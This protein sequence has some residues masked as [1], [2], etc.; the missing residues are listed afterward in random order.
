MYRAKIPSS[1]VV[2]DLFVVGLKHNNVIWLSN[3]L[4]YTSQRTTVGTTG[5]SRDREH[6]SG[7]VP[8][9][10]QRRNVD[11]DGSKPFDGT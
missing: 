9:Q 7:A 3:H 10:L 2:P 6:C 4:N 8:G 5:S 1:S 11:V